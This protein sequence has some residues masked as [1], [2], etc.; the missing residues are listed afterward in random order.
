MP[1]GLIRGALDVPATSRALAVSGILR[2]A[3]RTN[4]L[5]GF[6]GDPERSYGPEANPV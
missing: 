6:Q 2:N 5:P 1:S 4:T 3:K